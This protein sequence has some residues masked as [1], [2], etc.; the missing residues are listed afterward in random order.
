M[1]R[2]HEVVGSIPG[3]TQWIKDP[4]F[5]MSFSVGHRHSLDLAVLWLWYRPAAITP[6]GH[7]AWEPP[8]AMTVALKRQKMKK[9]KKK[10]PQ[11]ATGEKEHY[12][13]EKIICK[14]KLSKGMK[15]STNTI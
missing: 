12:K 5:A 4:A 15:S 2:N 11:L 10:R 13:W 14:G 3:F 9:K 1:T 8:Y 7:L 6:I